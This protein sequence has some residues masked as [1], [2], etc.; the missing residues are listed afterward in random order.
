MFDSLPDTVN[1]NLWASQ[2]PKTPPTADM[3]FD[4][5]I[6]GYIAPLTLY[7]LQAQE[8]IQ[9]IHVKW[10]EDIARYDITSIDWMDAVP[11][12]ETLKQQQLQSLLHTATFAQFTHHKNITSIAYPAA[13]DDSIHALYV[14]VEGEAPKPL[15][16]G[17]IIPA[18]HG[19]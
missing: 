12:E 14:H 18:L 8:Q 9:T 7:Q 1:F 15:T 11:T 6:H 13:D 2:R 4:L 3:L 16:Y 10:N 5:G 17:D 19:E